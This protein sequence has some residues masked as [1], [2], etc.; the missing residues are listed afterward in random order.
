MMGYRE[1]TPGAVKPHRVTD[2]VVYIFAVVLEIIPNHEIN[3]MGGVLFSV[4]VF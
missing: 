2:R 3:S 1:G 4:P